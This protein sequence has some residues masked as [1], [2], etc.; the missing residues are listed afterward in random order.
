[1]IDL[2]MHNQMQFAEGRS[3]NGLI[4]SAPL[5][6]PLQPDSLFYHFGDD[7][8]L[9]SDAATYSDRF[10]RLN[11][12]EYSNPS[13][14]ESSLIRKVIDGFKENGNQNASLPIKVFTDILPLDPVYFHGEA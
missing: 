8:C 12:V 3:F 11:N 10:L 7:E 4:T 1:M 2:L 13:K 6:Y 9:S 14:R 5:A